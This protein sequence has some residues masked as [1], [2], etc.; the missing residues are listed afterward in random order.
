[1]N[2]PI[3]RDEM[4]PVNLLPSGIVLP[5]AALSVDSRVVTSWA[6]V[7][8][9]PSVGDLVFGRVLRV[10][11][12]DSL[13][14][15]QGHM[16]PIGC[17]SLAVLVYGTRYAPD[18]FEGRVPDRPVHEADLLSRSGVVGLLRTR[19][20][21]V[22][23]PTRI[24]ILGHVLD[25]D[26]T[27]VNTRE[28]AEPMSSEHV[29]PGHRLARMILHVGTSM[30]AGKTT[31][32]RA[33]C[34]ALTEL[35]HSVRASKITGT[36]SVND[37]HAMQ[38]AGAA[39]V[40]DFARLGHPSTYMLEEDELVGIFASLESYCARDPDGFWVVELA[41]G[42]LQRETAMLLQSPRL[43]SRINRMVLSAADALGA[44]GGLHVLREQ[45][46]LVPDAVSGRISSS[47]L[48]LR[49]LQDQVDIPVFRNAQP[50]IAQLGIIL[51]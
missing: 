7:D 34:T 46:G 15:G 37:I 44:L 51:L 4:Q 29:R 42:I 40:A 14:D 3:V 32:A 18:F 1:M 22:R 21:I 16:H 49:E 36:A 25:E 24:E 33:C 31:S 27:P 48:A 13:Q 9:A 47:P 23:D 10:G 43:Q 30:N 6:K 5:G 50:D 45:F 11:E 38:D 28:H 17:G 12:H 20:D 2:K 35:G 8:R 41:D 39:S 19:N 26:G